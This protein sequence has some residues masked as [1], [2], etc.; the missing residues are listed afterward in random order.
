MPLFIAVAHRVKI[1]SELS[2]MTPRP[3][4]WSFTDL[5]HSLASIESSSEIYSFIILELH[6]WSTWAFFH[7]LHKWGRAGMDHT[8]ILS[9]RETLPPLPLS[10]QEWI[11]GIELWKGQIAETEMTLE[12]NPLLVPAVCSKW[13]DLILPPH[14]CLPVRLRSILKTSI[15]ISGNKTLMWSWNLNKTSHFLIKVH[16]M[17]LLF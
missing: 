14:S 12:F 4:S 5:S 10:S 8:A 1:S 3:L 7:Y 17:P 13:K 15:N 16:Y 11:P 2:T 9:S 6:P